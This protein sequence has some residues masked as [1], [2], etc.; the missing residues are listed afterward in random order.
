MFFFWGYFDPEKVFF[1]EKLDEN[2]YFSGDL[3]G[4]SVKKEAL[5]SMRLC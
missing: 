3:T 4:V 2:K 1:V 5:A